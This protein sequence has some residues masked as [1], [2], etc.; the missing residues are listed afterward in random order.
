M[1]HLRVCGR[2]SC[3]SAD[4]DGLEIQPSQVKYLTST[5]WAP[6]P[7]RLAFGVVAP[8]LSGLS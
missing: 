7:I 1:G 3:V 5:A 6:P 8:P 4:D 2:L